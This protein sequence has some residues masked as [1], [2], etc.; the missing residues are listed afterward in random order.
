MG[1]GGKHNHEDRVAIVTGAAGGLG[2]ATVQ[3]LAG[4]G[5]R[6]LA[7]D[8][9]ELDDGSTGNE[10]VCVRADVSDEAQVAGLVAQAIETWGRLDAM[11]NNAAMLGPVVPIE[12]YASQD[13]ARVLDVNVLGVWLG[14]KYALPHLQS[15]HGAVLNTSSVAGLGG[16]TNLSGYTAAKHAVV[17]LTR[18]AAIE[19]AA[20][21]VRVNALCPGSMDTPMLWANADAISPDRAEAQEILEE[22]IPVG[23]LAAPAEVAVAAAWLLVDAP[24]FMTGAIVPVDGGQTAT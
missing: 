21:G 7:A 20:R 17:G 9:E 23:R 6:V 24:G 19:Y 1:S 10:I 15:T 4:R 16:W 2:S 3:A 8:V 11:F 22:A 12:E 13:F 5:L 18:A 14:M